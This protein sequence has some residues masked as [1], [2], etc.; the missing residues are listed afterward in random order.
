MSNIGINPLNIQ[1]LK[2]FFDKFDFEKDSEH[3]KQYIGLVK[4]LAFC[5][6]VIIYEGYDLIKEDS[7]GFFALKQLMMT[8]TMFPVFSL[9]FYI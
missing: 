2:S 5:Q 9:S 7:F 8:L 4:E 3:I 1:D 6:Q